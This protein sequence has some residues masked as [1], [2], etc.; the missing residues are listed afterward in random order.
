[1]DNRNMIMR[2]CPVLIVCL[3][4]PLL[5]GGASHW[6]H[7][8]EAD[9]KKGKFH[10]VVATNLGDLK[11]SR[12]VKTLL[13][14]DA[15]VTSVYALAQAPDG[16]I[17]A[18]TGPQG[19]IL[20]VEGEKVSAFTKLD[21]QNVFALLID[22][23]GKLLAGTGGEKGRVL[24]FDKPGDK[25]VELLAPDGVQYVW[26]LMQ[27]PDKTIYAATGPTGQIHQIQ[28]D[29]RVSVLFDCD[30]NNILSLVSDGKDLLYAGTDPNGLVYRVNRKTRESFVLYD[31]NEAEISALALDGAGNLY[32]GTSQT[33]DV[34]EEMPG[35]EH[36]GQADK[37]GRPEGPADGAPLP[38]PKPIDPKPPEPPKP[39]PGEPA[40]IPRQAPHAGLIDGKGRGVL[41]FLDDEPLPPGQPNPAPAP[42]TK[43]AP[44]VPQPPP[45]VNVP[46][47][48]P[49]P[50]GNAIYKIT[51]EGFV[52]EVFRQPGM[53]LSLVEKEGTLLVGSGSEG[54]IYQVNV[55]AEETVVLAKVDPRQ[56]M[57]LLP[58][59]D[60]QV[61]L[62][63]A[64]TGQIAV[65]SSGYAGEGTF[66]SGVLDA[67]QIARFGKVRL[68]G[69]LP[70][71]TTLTLATRS[72]NLQEPN[73]TGW[74]K[75]SEEL[76]AVEYVQ[77]PSPAARFFQYRLTLASKDAGASPVVEDVDVAYQIP[78]LAPQVRS[79]KVADAEGGAM[80]NP[81]PIAVPMIAIG[82]PAPRETPGGRMRTISWEAADPNGDAAEYTLHFRGGSSG[83]WVVLQEKVKENQYQW[84]TRTVA[85]G[86][87]QVRL[88]ASDEKANPR[89]E[90]KSASRVSD[91]IVVDNTPPAIGDVKSQVEGKAVSIEAKVIDRT[92][93]VTL[94]EYSVNSKSEW[95]AV[96]A[97]DGIFDSPEET[98]SL[99]VDGMAAGA[100]Q[101]TLR[102][103]DAHGNQAYETVQ[104]VVK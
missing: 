28:A 61:I 10:Q 36:P 14:Q 31:A 39:N 51:P 43:P 78:N 16:T 80:P 67:A 103:T 77:A 37:T 102:A 91:P 64:N 21:D 54:L 66:T 40:P 90:G 75:W 79:I 35:A 29:G 46:G 70:T 11:L 38:A 20:K 60:G 19:V 72:G 27:A 59:K 56:V 15:R 22:A 7:S 58:V 74:S 18:G 34:V 104:I 44:G 97:G 4:A 17:Y 68:H 92:S 23:E 42:G 8:A 98:V 88:T 53:V 84:D 25:P 55:A 83:P 69:S 82:A 49:M 86:R 2:I 63:L 9:F 87:Y 41:F 81:M 13:A 65:M 26:K 48:V 32:A 85:D 93:V 52:T 76:P 95:Q 5:A 71:G 96:R 94:V 47:P 50:E 12:A 3:A 24:R 45:G 101:I 6:T 99:R 62:G 33:T 73:D 57:T 89:G 1:M 30:E 100:Y